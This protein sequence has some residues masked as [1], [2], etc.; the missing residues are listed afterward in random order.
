M[1]SAAGAEIAVLL[2]AYGSPRHPEEIEAYYTHVRRGKAPPADLLDELVGRYAAIGGVSPLVERTEAQATALQSA[3]D[4][5]APG[6]LRVVLGY[7]HASPFI[8]DAVEGIVL[9]GVRRIVGLVLA[10]HHS[11]YSVGQYLER[12]AARA[13]TLDPSVGFLGIERWH[14]EPAYLD[15]L[16]GAVRARLGELPARTKVL[17]TAHSLPQRIVADGDTYPDQLRQT[18]QAVATT[19]GLG[20]E[21][22]GWDVAWQS[23]GR[24]PEPWIGPDVTEVLRHL[25][26]SGAA[27]GVLVCPCGF[28]SDHLEILYDLDIEAQA[29][30]GELG[31][32]FARTEVVNDDGAVMGALAERVLATVL[33][34]SAD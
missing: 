4:T 17:F 21:G 10:P 29:R 31:L 23:A 27:D 18:A 1:T 28:V 6:E 16:A 2:M 14:L 3:L 34:T 19:L 5:R 13:A 12:A 30:A 15:F 8:E 25:A 20:L 24:T 9:G 32:A 7:K 33:T 22:A 26:G 11:A